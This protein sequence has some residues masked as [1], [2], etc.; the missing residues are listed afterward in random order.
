MIDSIL[1]SKQTYLVGGAVRDRLLG[2]PV[3]DRDYVVVGSTPQ[4][5]LDAGF[6]SVGKDFPVFL[7]PETSEEYA[8]ARTERKSGRGYHGFVFHAD[9]HVT[10]EDDLAR[11][12][13]TINAIAEDENGQLTDPFNGQADIEQRL[14]RHV[15][16][17]FVEDPVRILRAARFMAR[18]APLG[19]RI[20]EETMSLMKQMVADG[21]V[22][23]LVP[24]R[25]FAELR[26]ALTEPTPSAFL[27]TLRGCDALAVLFPEIEA[28][29]GVPQTAQWHPEIDTGI[30][31]ELV[32]DEAAK[33]HAGDDVIG[34]AALV[35]DLGKALTPEDV[36]PSHRMHEQRGLAPITDLCERLKAP[37]AHRKLALSAC[38]DHLLVHKLFE[39]RAATIHDLIAR[40][41]GFKNDTH[42]RNIVAVC[43]CDKLGRGDGNRNP[44]THP[45]PQAE[46]LLQLAA[47][48]RQVTVASLQL[49]DGIQGAAIGEKLRQARTTAIKSASST[50]R[51]TI[52]RN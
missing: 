30:H 44:E 24:E 9:E 33:H 18:F 1:M 34:F 15:S 13:F 51:P 29:Y 28:L 10:L 39:L 42:L 14:I 7:H 22:D 50:L 4:A 31:T 8:L 45:Y 36:L 48:G 21:E 2:R 19:F 3:K 27:Q 26:T 12:D 25:V 52:H 5:M 32:V 38:R 37:N 20:A 16:S 6:Q 23:H 11:R 43:R 17:A 49:P 46:A 41:G 40:N 35:H 47:A